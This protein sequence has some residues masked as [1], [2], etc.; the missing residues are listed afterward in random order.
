MEVHNILSLCCGGYNIYNMPYTKN[1]TFTGYE[2][3]VLL[4]H[5]AKLIFIALAYSRMRVQIGLN[6]YFCIY[7]HI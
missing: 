5:S 7:M 6:F 1:S 4:L 3:A 2:F